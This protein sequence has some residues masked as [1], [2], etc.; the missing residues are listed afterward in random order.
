[1]RPTL[2][3]T[4]DFPPRT[5]GIQSYVHEL[6]TRL[7][8]GKLVVYAP[9]WPQSAEF[10][11]AQPFPV[12]RHP[13][14]LMLPTRQ[15]ARRA[16]ELIDRHQLTAAWFGAAAPLAMLAPALRRA[17]LRRTV[18]S[19]HGH[20]VGWAM[21]PGSRQVLRRIGNA[22]DVITFVSR[23]ARGRIAAALGPM[24]ALEYL[25]P[26]VDTS[27]F[28]PNVQQRAAIRARHG[29]DDAP[30]LVCISRLVTRKGQDQ[31]IRALPRIRQQI[32]RARLLIVGGGPKRDRLDHLAAG[33]GEAVVFAGRVDVDE[34]P[35]YYN[36]GDVFAM[37]CRTR[38]KGLDVEGL[39]IVFLEA[40]ACGLAVIAGDSG[41]APET[42]R[43]ERSGLVVDGRDIEQLAAA[44]IQLLAD[45]DRARHWGS[46]GRASVTKN[47]NWRASADRLAQLLS[48]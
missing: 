46:A 4:N 24:A 44:C 43:P 11:A 6:A 23:Y 3:V 29:L 8:T 15:V 10:D 13:T 20:E 1:M 25:P 48:T 22:N 42:V 27:V 17:G 40:S 32:P 37:P 19:T 39:G 9:S 41:G 36:A 30:T 26:G 45:P 18:A 14:S 7:P 5:G 47:W 33:L 28:A 34:L 38:G 31:L 2:L 16:A 35:A 12:Y 21:L